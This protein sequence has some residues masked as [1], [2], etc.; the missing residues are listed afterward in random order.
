MR[1]NEVKHHHGPNETAAAEP[2]RAPEIVGPH[3]DPRTKRWSR[4]AAWAIEAL[5]LGWTLARGYFFKAPLYSKLADPVADPTPADLPGQNPAAGVPVHAQEKSGRAADRNLDSES[6]LNVARRHKRGTL[7]V[8]CAFALG[9]AGGV[10]FLHAYWF[11]GNNQLLGASGAAFLGGF[12][13]ALVLYSHWLTSH[14]EATEPREKLPSSPPE[15]EALLVDYCAGTHEIHRRSLL[16]WMGLA[17]TGVFGAMVLSLL[18]SLGMSPYP[19]LS[20]TVWKSGERLMTLDGKPISID[21]LQ[22]GSTTTVFPENSLG[23]ARTQTVLIRV[24][25]QLLQLPRER[26][27]WAPMG[28]VAYSRVC[29]HAGCTVGLFESTTNLLL[30]PCHQSTFDV[31]RA[32]APTGGPAARPLP[33]LPLYADS[34]GNLR[35]AGEFTAPPGPGF[36]GM[37]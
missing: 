9:I 22:P 31:L 24:Q 18:R 6:G 26:A 17:G 37:S 16:K 8:I 2:A 12:G 20:T 23:S 32:A 15:R 19:S 3:A 35:A 27:D 14:K 30:C 11:G 29:T 1:E 7:F 4:K 36:W 10:G 13:A 25:E 21:S 28:Y 34:D 5:V 33:Q